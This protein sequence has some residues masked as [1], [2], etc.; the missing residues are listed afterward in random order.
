MKKKYKLHEI[1]RGST[2]KCDQWTIT[3]HHLDGMYSYCT[4]DWKEAPN[5]V[6]HLSVMQEL[7]K[8]GYWDFYKLI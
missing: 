7:E 5:N 6:T 8:I 2:I 3:F 1:P 4:V